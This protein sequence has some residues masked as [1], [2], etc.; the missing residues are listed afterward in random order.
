MKNKNLIWIIIAVVAL[1][2]IIAIGWALLRRIPSPSPIKPAGV[3]TAEAVV[4]PKV[5]TLYQKGEGESDLAAFVSRELAKKFKGMAV[6]RLINV[7]DD[8]QMAGYFGVNS[9]PAVIFQ[10]PSGRVYS[11][12][13]GY[14]DQK[15]ILS[16]LQSMPKS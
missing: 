9:H 4:L 16:I 3:V 1:I 6:F 8:P 13:E 2:I 10:L 7:L 5:I 12:Y 14:L 15:K 11:K